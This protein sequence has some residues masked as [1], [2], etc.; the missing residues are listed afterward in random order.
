MRDL[1]LSW[2]VIS[3]AFRYISPTTTLLHPERGVCTHL[4]WKTAHLRRHQRKRDLLI[5]NNTIRCFLYSSDYRFF[6]TIINFLTISCNKLS[7]HSL[8][9]RLRRVS[10]RNNEAVDVCQVEV[11][12][13]RKVFSLFLQYCVHFYLS[14]NETL[15]SVVSLIWYGY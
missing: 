14:F 9:Q 13:P 11:L 8:L 6:L 10:L 4:Y 7:E 3:P 1:T 15:Q 2:C 12:P 5:A